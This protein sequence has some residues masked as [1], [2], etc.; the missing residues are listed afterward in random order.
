M[1]MDPPSIADSDGTV[2]RDTIVHPGRDWDLD[3]RDLELSYFRIDRRAGL[4][5]G[6]IL[7]QIGCP[8]TLTLMVDGETYTLDEPQ[9]LGPLLGQYPD[10]LAKAS[11]D[12][13]G[14]LRL[15]F[16]R[17]WIVDVPPKTHYEAWQIAGPGNA[18]VVCPPDGDTLA[19]WEITDGS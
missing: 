12:Q 4:Q 9:E 5:F 1:S 3:L 13:D 18:P 14:T 16:R 15:V 19:V 11:V 10:T 7:I 6:D 2:R 8:L 17:G